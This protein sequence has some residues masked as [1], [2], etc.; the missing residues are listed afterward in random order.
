MASREANGLD[1]TAVN[2][3]PAATITPASLCGH[4][5]PPALNLKNNGLSVGDVDGDSGF[6]TVTL[7]VAEGHADCDAGRP[8]CSDRIEQRH[9]SGHPHGQR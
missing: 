2:D 9:F 3:G 7:S 4:Q 8:A 6:E 1:I 5:Q